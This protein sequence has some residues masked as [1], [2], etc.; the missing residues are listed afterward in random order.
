MH[1]MGIKSGSLQEATATRL[2]EVYLDI[3]P[4][5]FSRDTTDRHKLSRY[6]LKDI[7]GC[8]VGCCLIV[9]IWAGAKGNPT[10][11]LYSDQATLIRERRHNNQI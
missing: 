3:I 11:Q 5:I 10:E 7:L 4:M 9:C 8:P 2:Q 1:A 6:V